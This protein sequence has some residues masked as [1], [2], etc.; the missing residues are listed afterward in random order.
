VGRGKLSLLAD[1]NEGYN[2][3]DALAFIRNCGIGVKIFEQPVQRHSIDELRAVK[4][5]GDIFNVMVFAD[6]SVYTAH[7]A[8]HFIKEGA[9][10]G[11]N[12]KL[13][14]NG[15]FIEAL[16]IAKLAI[17]SGL[18]IMIGGMVETRLAMTAGLHLA[19]TIG[20]AHLN[21]VD[22]DTPMLL[23]ENILTGGMIY[24]GPKL[25]LPDAP[26]LGVDLK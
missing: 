5:F 11:F 15:G 17:D 23:E 22:L 26:G 18:Q 16:R 20:H 3:S 8:V 19:R 7:D 1:A 14:K 4:Q 6:E 25:T 21:W 9:V 13:M 12:L 10:H 2:L 24:D